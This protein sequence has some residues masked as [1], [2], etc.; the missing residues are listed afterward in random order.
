MNTKK[1]VRSSSTALR[2]G[3][4]IYATYLA[5]FY[6]LWLFTGVDYTA[7][8]RDETSIRMWYALPTLAGSL[9]VVAT[10]TYLRQWKPTL[11]ESKR[12]GPAWVNIL[13]ISMLIII[14]INF[15]NTNGANVTPGLLIWSILGGVGVGIGE[16]IITRGS[17]LIGLRAHFTENKAWLYSTLAFAAL[18]IPNVLFGLGFAQMLLQLVLAFIMGSGFYAM[19][20]TTGTL[21]VPIILHGLWDSSIFLPQAT[22]SSQLNV[23][24]VLIYPLAIISTLAVLSQNRRTMSV[25]K[26]IITQA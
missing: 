25:H 11:Y 21:I 18:H 13:P 26:K 1:S 12:S 7:I 4:V 19:R 22:G 17:L 16:E 5:I 24:A 3:L 8:G 14:L 20:R 23:F 2:N 6:S 10:I 15:T 9:F